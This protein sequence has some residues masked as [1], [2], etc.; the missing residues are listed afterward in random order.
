MRTE[1]DGEGIFSGMLCEVQ[2]EDDIHEPHLTLLEQGEKTD[3]LHLTQTLLDRHIISDMNSF[4]L[5]QSK[6][7]L[8]ALRAIARRLV[9]GVNNDGVFVVFANRLSPVFQSLYFSQM[10]LSRDLFDSRRPPAAWPW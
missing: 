6:C 10:S 4:S 3:L 5:G 9:G 8:D 7:S 1:D 2:A